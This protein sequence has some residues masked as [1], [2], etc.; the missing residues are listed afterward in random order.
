VLGATGRFAPCSRLAPPALQAELRDGAMTRV[1]HLCEADVGAPVLTS[2]LHRCSAA[3]AGRTRGRSTTRRRGKTQ[4]R[5]ATKATIPAQRVCH[6]SLAGQSSRAAVIFSESAQVAGVEGCA[7]RGAT[8]DA[9]KNRHRFNRARAP[10]S[11]RHPPA[12]E[13]L[14]AP[15]ASDGYSGPLRLDVPAASPHHGRRL[16][17]GRFAPSL[18]CRYW[19]ASRHGRF[20]LRSSLCASAFPFVAIARRL[21]P[22][23]ACSSPVVGSASSALRDADSIGRQLFRP[24]LFRRCGR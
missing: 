12:R 3:L 17:V 13:P 19:V 21:L 11:H 9:G 16:G 15:C 4:P 1:R 18:R 6:G 8:E 14:G 22:W 10:E 24:Q 23:P 7:T 20:S 2:D 5:K